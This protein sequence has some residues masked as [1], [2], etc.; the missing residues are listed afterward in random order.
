M[1]PIR[2]V[3]DLVRSAEAA[4]TSTAGVQT[5]A[6]RL[7]LARIEDVAT[8]LARLETPD[9]GPRPVRPARANQTPV[10]L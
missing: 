9:W 7:G 10:E 1:N 5:V 8:L 3:Q 4:A 6:Q 2:G